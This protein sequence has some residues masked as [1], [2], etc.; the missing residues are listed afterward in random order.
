MTL[1]P[2]DVYEAWCHQ[3]GYVCMI[4]EL[5]GRPT[6]PG[7]TLGA[8]YIVG[9]FDSV[10]EMHTTYDRYVGWSGIELTGDAKRPTGFRGVKQAEL[11][12]I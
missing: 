10:R 9:W 7:D 8:A 11:K 5:G 4:E 1:Q 12:A 3:R 6:E 2:S